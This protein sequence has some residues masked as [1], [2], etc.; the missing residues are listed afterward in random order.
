M[1]G[2]EIITIAQMRAIDAQSAEAGVSTRALM[3]NAGRAVAEAIMARFSPRATAVLCGPGNNGGDGWVCA[4][5]LEDHGWP[6]WVE[7]LAP[8]TA[9]TGDAADAARAF[10]GEV[11]ALGVDNPMAELFVDALFGAGL[12][13][14]LE[15]DC[16]RLASSLPAARVVAIDVPS[17]VHGEGA[18]LDGP[19][20]HADLTVTFVRKKPAHVLA[21]TRAL[22]GEV[23][24]ADIGAPAHVVAA[25]RVTLF[26]NDPALWTLP[27]PARDAHKHARGHCMVVS[28]PPEATGA[29]RL[30]ARAAL[31]VGAG[32]VTLVCTPTALPI[33]AA[34]VS[35]IMTRVA[36][37][38]QD[39]ARAAREARAVVIGPAAGVTAITR[40]AA[41]ALLEQ[42]APLVLDADALSVFAN[43]PAALFTRLRAGDVLTPHPGEFRRL[44]P[45]LALDAPNR[46]EAARGAAARAGAVV[47]L[48]GPDTVVAAPDGRA[49]VNTAGSPFL[50]TAGSGDVLAG[51]IAGLLAQGMAGFEAAA[52]AAWL[53]GQVGARLGPGL[54][55]EDLPEA[56]PSVLNELAPADLKAS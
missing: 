51:F 34:H 4:R 5:V 24:V 28:G 25:Q 3:E 8:P 9:L 40:A 33:V 52:A 49:I 39:I 56:L 21:H 32:L 1:S 17:G 11:C 22:C 50:A 16:A 44:F 54:I 47:L 18:P 38:P 6:V 53:H 35:A 26:E 42:D 48:K 23:I 7:T 2:R 45:D 37:S 31:R 36:D 19:T 12:S 30:A 15:G 41:L 46:I 14:P 43:A 55:A 10:K 29:A 27:W 20:F 13:K